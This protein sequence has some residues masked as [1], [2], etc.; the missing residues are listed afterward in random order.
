MIVPIL[1]LST[2]TFRI[3]GHSPTEWEAKGVALAGYTLAT[4][5]QSSLHSPERNSSVR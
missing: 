5:G 2:Y 3:A 1:V 4:L